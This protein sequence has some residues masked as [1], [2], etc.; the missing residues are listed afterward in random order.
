MTPSSVAAMRSAMSAPYGTVL[1][2]S[3]LTQPRQACPDLEGGLAA[4]YLRQ[5]AAA[6]EYLLRASG[7]EAP[8]RELRVLGGQLDANAAS[9]MRACDDRSCP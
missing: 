4:E 5:L 2:G 7:F 8:A 3:P 6:V 1:G 9:A